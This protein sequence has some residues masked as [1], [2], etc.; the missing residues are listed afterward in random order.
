MTQVKE[1]E[2][3]EIVINKVHLKADEVEEEGEVIDHQ[4]EIKNQ[5]KEESKLLLKLKLNEH[6]SILEL[7]S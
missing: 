6:V 1:E 3:E 7:L 5:L 4:E 2:S